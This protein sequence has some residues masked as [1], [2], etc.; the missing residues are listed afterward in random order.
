MP[1]FAYSPIRH[2][3]NIMYCGVHNTAAATATTSTIGPG[4]VASASFS[5]MTNSPSKIMF[6]TAVRSCCAAIGK[7]SD[8]RYANHGPTANTKKQ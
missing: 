7:H 4:S 5:V 1:T 8:A 3:K 6:A 2:T